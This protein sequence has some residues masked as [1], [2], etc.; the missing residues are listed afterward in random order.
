MIVRRRIVIVGMTNPLSRDPDHALYTQPPGCT[1]HRLWQMA[2]ARTG[3]SEEA[4]LDMTDRRNLCLGEW[5][6][7]QAR[8]S[9]RDMVRELRGKVTIFLGADVAGCFPSCGMTAQWMGRWG[10]PPREPEPWIHLPH[11]SGRNHWYNDPVCRAGVEILLAD[12]IHLC[13]EEESNDNK[14]DPAPEPVYSQQPLLL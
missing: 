13:T 14:E 5:D 4:W 6:R 10:T 9:A 1:G 2:K 3:I 12:L 11:P 7:E 8:V